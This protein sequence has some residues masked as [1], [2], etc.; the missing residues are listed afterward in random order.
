MTCARNSKLNLP[1]L[2][3]C[4][5]CYITKID[6]TS[7]F[8]LT[9]WRARLCVIADHKYDFVS[10]NLLEELPHDGTK[11]GNINATWRA[12]AK[13]LY[14]SHHKDET[15]LSSFPEVGTAAMTSTTPCMPE[16]HTLTQTQKNSHRVLAK[17]TIRTTHIEAKKTSNMLRLS[18]DSLGIKTSGIHHNWC[19]CCK[20]TATATVTRRKEH[21]APPSWTVTAKHIMDISMKLNS[22]CRH[23]H[24][25]VT[26]TGMWAAC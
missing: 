9:E 18:M 3:S 21:E 11:T 16:I 6:G 24:I 5:I 12:V 15:Y 1:Q 10:F 14:A 19:E 13:F 4:K 26:L 25:P 23:D 7:Y 2:N 8:Y 20:H 17:H 22:I